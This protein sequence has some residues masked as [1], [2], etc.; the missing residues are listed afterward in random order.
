MVTGS[1]TPEDPPGSGSAGQ[2]TRPYKGLPLSQQLGELV[3]AAPT[4][5]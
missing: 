1:V 2:V 4:A 3:P 5:P